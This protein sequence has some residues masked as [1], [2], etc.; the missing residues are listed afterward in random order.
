MQKLAYEELTDEQRKQFESEQRLAHQEAY[1]DRY[2]QSAKRKTRKG[3]GE[4]ARAR[5]QYA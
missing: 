4:K 1:Q 5:K 3:K 2:G